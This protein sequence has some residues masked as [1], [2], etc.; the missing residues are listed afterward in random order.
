VVDTSDLQ[1]KLQDS[2]EKSKTF[3]VKQRKSF[4]SARF[5]GFLGA[6]LLGT[7]LL[8][9]KLFHDEEAYLQVKADYEAGQLVV[10]EDYIQEKSMSCIEDVY[11]DNFEENM[12]VDFDDLESQQLT[13][14]IE[15]NGADFVKCSFNS[16]AKSDDVQ[17][18]YV[19]KQDFHWSIL[20]IV[21]GTM[22]GLY[23]LGGLNSWNRQRKYGNEAK[24]KANEL[25]L[26]D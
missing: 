26:F 25:K 6:F 8:D 5:F 3:E 7:D 4:G 12:G 22:G 18:S 19:Y 9:L 17:K 20:T 16:M 11:E 2:E 23:T 14:I 15:E 21:W 10:P 13:K 24:S 1:K